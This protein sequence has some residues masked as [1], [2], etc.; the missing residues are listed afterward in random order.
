MPEL[1]S[2][3]LPADPEVPL[4]EWASIHTE[5]HWIYD[6]AVPA[7][8]RDHWN[9]GQRTEHRAWLVRRGRARV[10]TASGTQHEAGPGMWLF[11]PLH[12]FHQQFSEDARILSLHF[13]CLWPSGESLFTAREAVVLA[14]ARR[15][16]LERR[17]R[18]LEQ[19]VKRHFPRAGTNY[20]AGFASYSR[21]LALHTLFLK[22]LGVWVEV[23]REEG[24]GFTRLAAG[25]DRVMRALRRLSSAPLQ[26]GF[27]R[28]ALIRETGLSETHL[29][30]LFFDEY[31]MTT[32][33]SWEARRLR[34][35]KAC[36]ETSRMPIKE[37]AYS[38]GFRSDSHFMIWFK[39]QTGK[40]PTEYRKV[41]RG[42]E[43]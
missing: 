14:S 33:K 31:G 41:H 32:R 39:K 7:K 20:Y 30:R 21:F 35:A 40:R 2:A 19:M 3:S 1:P 34:E 43:I 28:D 6:H 29:N 18:Q 23:Q 5:L 16:A 27:P 42:M 9:E 26:D 37:I 24:A 17:A 10:I 13:R 8:Y 12:G 25:D 15:P 36:L 22:W 4:R 38:L 11:P